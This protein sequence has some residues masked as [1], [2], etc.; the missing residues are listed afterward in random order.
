MDDNSTDEVIEAEIVT[1]EEPVATQIDGG[2]VLINM[3]SMIKTHMAA[4]D[5][6][7]QEIKEHKGI[8]DDIFLNDPTFQEHSEKAKEAS[9][10]K[11]GTRAEILKRPQAA[12][13]NNKIKALKSQLSE[14]QDALSDYLQEYAR[15]SGTNEIE[16]DDGE[17]REIVYS[18]KLVRKSFR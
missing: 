6:L 14:T 17:V 13:L 11:Q 3:E 2:S 16:G 8:L 15:L 18:A 7:T 5:K 4:L 9:K 10:V 1:T 12:D